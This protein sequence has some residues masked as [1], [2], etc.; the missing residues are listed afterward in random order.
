VFTKGKHNR[1]V[2][3]RLLL[4]AGSAAGMAAASVLAATAAFGLF[5]GTAPT[6]TSS[7]SAGT[8]TLASNT[9]GACNV[10]A[11]LPGATPTPCKLKATYS[12]SVLAYIGLDVLIE[13]QAGSGGTKLYNP[14]DSANDLQITI[15]DNQ[16]TPVTYVVPTSVTPP[17]PGS[18]PSGST[19]YALND[20][21]VSL[22]GLSSGTS[23]TFS[24]TV[25]LPTGSATG[26]QGGSAQIILT[27]HAVQ[28]ANNGSTS[29]CTAGHRCTTVSWS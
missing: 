21:L 4:V 10:A 3:K 28:A 9:S 8:V 24:T 26:Y 27:A 7:F 15:K 29:T 6:K 20:E 18:A 12:G 23:I 1:R 2:S 11:V 19:C 25:S 16:G 17:C 14:A 22:T 13:A 5:G